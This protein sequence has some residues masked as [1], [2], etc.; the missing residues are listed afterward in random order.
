M[1]STSKQTLLSEFE[2]ITYYDYT[3]REKYSHD[4]SIFKVVPEMIMEPRSREE[5][6]QI[7]KR[8]HELRQEDD[9][10]SLT[11]RA[12]GTGLSGGSLN[13]SIIINVL[14]HFTDLIEL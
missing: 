9:S 14:P 5:L 12:A 10:L 6:A 13:T 7:V 8:I 3:S 11:T 4:E 1:R 2:E